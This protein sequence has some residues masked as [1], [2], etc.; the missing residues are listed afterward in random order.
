MS[1]KFRRGRGFS[2]IELLVV[3]AIISILIAILLPAVQQAREAARRIQCRNNLKQFGL[4]LANYH[5]SYDRFP[6]GGTR[7]CC[8]SG[9]NLGFIPRL[10][11]YLDL[12]T[13]YDNLNLNSADATLLPPVPPATTAAAN[14]VINVP[15][16][17]AI[18]P[19]DSNL[20][21]NP[22]G[23]GPGGIGYAT[24]NY[25][26]SAGSMVLGS[27]DPACTVYVTGVLINDWPDA[28]NINTISGMGGRSGACI[29]ISH[30]RDGTSNVI[31][32]GEILPSCNPNG[33][34]GL[35]LMDGLNYHAVTAA[36]INDYTTCPW[37]TGSQIRFPGCTTANWNIGWGFRSMHSGG[38]N[39]LFVDGSVHVL[40]SSINYL[41]YQYLGGR[42]DGNVVG[43]Y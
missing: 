23:A 31:H 13:I 27:T 14:P 17:I 24:T 21:P 5:N 42:S 32:M 15:I 11:P 28:S 4:A 19:S 39:F 8:G 16:T 26:G 22:N 36:P 34:G 18:C 2:L 43:T 37:A 1:Q 7:D 25:D 38:A 41:T 40:S 6:P 12:G 3:I 20:E 29:G 35:W 9:P 30:V 10:F 33:F